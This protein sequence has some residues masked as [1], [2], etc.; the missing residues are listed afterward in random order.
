MTKIKRKGEKTLIS[1]EYKGP[2]E[3]LP[4]K[5]YIK[6]LKK[7]AKKK[8][9]KAYGKPIL[10]YYHPFNEMKE[11]R[12]RI[13]IAKPIKKLRKA[14]DG[15]KLKFLPPMKVASK[16]FKG[17]PLDYPKVYEEMYDWI[18]QKGYKP[19]GNRMEVI[20]DFSKDEEGELNIKSQIQIPV[21]KWKK[22]R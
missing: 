5:D 10:F 2:I 16:N 1:L 11:E 8:K 15:Y 12:F 3:E 9:A 20:N 17:E 13:D 7:W 18:E 21:E 4:L 22:K 14:G 6:D 19:F